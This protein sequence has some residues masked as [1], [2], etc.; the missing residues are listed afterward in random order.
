M[1]IKTFADLQRAITA[2]R[3]SDVVAYDVE[4]TGV[5]VRKDRIIGMG[6]STDSL[7]TYYLPLYFWNISENKLLP[8][9]QLPFVKDFLNALKGTRLIAHNAYFDCEITL[10][11]LGVDLWEDLYLDTIML[12]HT[13]DEE[14]PFG[15][16]QIAKMLWGVDELEEQRAMKQSIK[17]NGGGVHDYYKADMRLL[18]EYCEQ[19]CALTIR[20]YRHYFK[21][22]QQE[23]LEQFFFEDEVMP[24]YKEVTRFMQSRGLQLDMNLL[25]QA[26][27]DI[28]KEINNVED[29]I[30]SSIEQYL[31]PVF[32]KWFL[33]KD[34]PPRRSGEFAQYVVKY[35]GVDLP[36]TKSGR[37]SLTAKNLES[38]KE[39][40]FI[41]FL[42]WG[43]CLTAEQVED[44]QMLWWKDQG[45]K[46]MFNLSSK[47]HLKKLFFD[48]LKEEP[49]SRTDLGNPQVDDETLDVFAD[50]Y[51][52]VKD[53]QTYNR[54]NKIY[55]TYIKRFLDENEDGLFYSK[56]IQ[57]G[58]VS[59]RYSSDL[60]QLPRPV[61]GGDEEDVVTKFNNMIRKFFVA[62]EGNK[63]I[64]D[65]YCLHPDCE[66]LTDSGWKKVL[67]IED[68]DLVWQVDKTTLKGSW[69]KPSR[70]IKREYQGNMHTF[71]NRRGSFDVTDNH[72][73]LWTGQS[74]NV[75]NRGKQVSKRH[76][77]WVSLS[78]EEIPH[79]SCNISLCSEGDGTVSNF[80]SHELWMST[81]LS[82]DGSFISNRENYYKV[83]VSKEKKVNK[84]K[85]LTG[86]DP[87][88]VA[89]ILRGSRKVLPSSWFIKY[90]SP[91]LTGK[92][93]NVDLIGENQIDEFVEALAFW[94]GHVTKNKSIAWGST[95]R[96]LVE[97]VQQKLVRNGYEARLS[98]RHCEDINH[99][100]FYCLSIR[101]KGR[102]RVRP[103]DKRTYFYSGMVGCV[104]VDTGFILIRNNGQTF[105]TGNCSLEPHIFAH[106][107]GDEGLRDIFRKGL[108]FYSTIAIKTEGLEGYSPDPKDD[109]YLGKIAKE[110]RQA[111][112][113]YSLGIPYGLG[114]YSLALK[115][116]IE[117]YEGDQLVEDYLNAFPE[118]K[119]WYEESV[120]FC[121]EH[122][123]IKTQA[124]RIRHLKLAKEYWDTYGSVLDN[125]LVLWEKYHENPGLYARMKL[126]RK[127]YT[128]QIN[129][130]RNFQIQSLAASI[131]NRAAIGINRELALRGLDGY[132]CA[133]IHDQLVIHIREEDSEEGAR[134]VQ[135]IMENIFPLSLQLEA[136]P[137]I[138]NNLYEGH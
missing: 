41:D 104:T 75:T 46:Y 56:F 123:Y 1:F 132:V 35:A 118:L 22:L 32:T 114:G 16:K 29:R 63:F 124:G 102:L 97:A 58:T 40:R 34:M 127:A 100:S 126:I 49:V 51:D 20:V 31:Y 61:E 129:N 94:D 44:I 87:N 50:K 52:W 17:E 77:R 14:R 30:Q 117:Q 45:I 24:L 112:K 107:S 74:S 90:S 4:T 111:A 36:K 79:S 9:K 39:N 18:G 135:D 27:V 6:V 98:I 99:N 3:N 68:T 88:V 130:S 10:N 64:D 115:L 110:K 26:Q 93:I 73:M 66:L 5:N 47:H 128:N 25:Q 13:V 65:D 23:G 71:G 86:K 91:L 59:G 2:I 7:Q 60:Q 78:H 138:A 96:E 72:T 80:S 55:G 105:I 121:K 42:R 15:L 12:K 53:L 92:F 103:I 38:I 137:E 119:R 21:V 109:N 82:A 116:G 19:D 57:S 106:V 131:V 101:K 67:D 81:M 11:D 76:M 120:K 48:I 70:I 133:Q 89:T 125:S 37:Y 134:V 8:T 84:I 83:E 43:D 33:N 136:P 62:G 85:E 113:A 95:D 122:G 54:L 69:C 108:D 28:L